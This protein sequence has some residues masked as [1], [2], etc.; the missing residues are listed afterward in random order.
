MVLELKLFNEKLF[1]N[2]KLKGSNYSIGVYYVQKRKRK[3][4]KCENKKG[5]I[6]FYKSWKLC[7][8][9]CL[10]L[11]FELLLKDLELKHGEIIEE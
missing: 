5:K 3:G 7:R 6:K 4:K 2:L 8:L 1:L 10:H 11:N 9:D